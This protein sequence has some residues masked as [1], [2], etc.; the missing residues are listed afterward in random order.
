EYRRR[1]RA[2]KERW[3]AHHLRRS[4]K[5]P[6]PEAVRALVDAGYA[7]AIATRV[8]AFAVKR[9][10]G[11][12][13]ADE[14][15]PIFAEYRHWAVRASFRLADIDALAW[16]EQWHFNSVTPKHDQ[17]PGEF[18]WTPIDEATTIRYCESAI[19]K[20][21]YLYASGRDA[22]AVFRKLGTLDVFQTDEL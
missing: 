12:Q 3:A 17:R 16:K 20:A 21:R 1:D 18:T 9:P 8:R 14:G 6:T 7:A 15:E 19:V 5:E 13:P 22:K 2:L 10:G 11:L 4:G